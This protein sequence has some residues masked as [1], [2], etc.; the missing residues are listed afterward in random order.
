MNQKAECM[1]VQSYCRITVPRWI[2]NTNNKTNEKSKIKC[3]CKKKF[4]AVAEILEQYIR[5]LSQHHI[6]YVHLAHYIHVPIFK[7]LAV[8]NFMQDFA[9]LYAKTVQLHLWKILHC[10]CKNVAVM[11][12]N[13]YCCYTRFCTA[14]C[15]ILL[16]IIL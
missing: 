16:Y 9:K 2:C 14:Q 7:N 15:K 12:Q 6:I 8:I 10:L 3:Q 4:S 11:L 13:L 5:I 1:H